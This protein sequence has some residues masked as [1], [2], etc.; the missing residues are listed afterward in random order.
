MRR[1][2]NDAD[3]FNYDSSR[4]TG[5]FLYAPQT[6]DLTQAFNRIASEILRMAR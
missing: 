4:A 5:L 6:S 1:V 2:S 3:A